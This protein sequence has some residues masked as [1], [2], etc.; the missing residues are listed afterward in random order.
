M[1]GTS[2]PLLCNKITPLSTRGFLV[3]ER[4]FELARKIVNRLL[5]LSSGRDCRMNT[6]CSSQVNPSTVTF[7]GFGTPKV[8]VDERVATINLGAEEPEINCWSLS[9]APDCA[10]API[11]FQLLITMSISLASFKRDNSLVPTPAFT[12]VEK[13]AMC[14]RSVLPDEAQLAASTK[15][16]IG[17]SESYRSFS[18]SAMSVVVLPTPASPTKN[19]FVPSRASE[20]SPIWSIGRVISRDGCI[21]SQ[22]SRRAV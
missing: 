6:C 16:G 22:I 20:M 3:T 7:L 17:E 14:S 18:L 10:F 12:N 21:D 4:N 11:S 15:M 2:R 1:S 5:T 13:L 9:L 19:I 8:S